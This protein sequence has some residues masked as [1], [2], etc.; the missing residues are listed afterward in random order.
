MKMKSLGVVPGD[1][2]SI[3]SENHLDVC[4][5]FIG[6][7]FL[8]A[9]T[10]N[11]DINMSAEEIAL[12]INKFGPKII[13]AS[14]DVSEI[15]KQAKG[16]AVVVVF[17]SEEFDEFFNAQED[18]GAFRP[19]PLRSTDDTA[20]IFLSSGTTGVPKGVKIS[21]KAL[22]NQAEKLMSVVVFVA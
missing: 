6:A 9:V 5:P 15:L 10:A 16:D 4:V 11:M 12:F 7:M 21:H 20:H 3:C 18:E 22:L 8:G 1:V 17:G 2:V 19:S 13:F 14:E